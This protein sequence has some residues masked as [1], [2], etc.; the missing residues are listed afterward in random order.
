MKIYLAQASFNNLTTEHPVR[1]YVDVLKEYSLDRSH[2]AFTIA[3]KKIINGEIWLTLYTNTT[4]YSEE[5]I[6]NEEKQSDGDSNEEQPP[7]KF[8]NSVSKYAPKSS[9]CRSNDEMLIFLQKK[10]DLKK[11]GSKK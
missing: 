2:L 8:G 9:T 11:H 6:E 3:E 5:M 10:I 7:C 4:I 1:R